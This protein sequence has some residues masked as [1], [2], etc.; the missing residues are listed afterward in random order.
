[1]SELSIMKICDFFYPG[2]HPYNYMLPSF[3]ANKMTEDKL[4]IIYLS[5]NAIHY[6]VT[7]ELP[8]IKQK[9]KI[10]TGL[11]DYIIPY[12]TEEFDSKDYLKILDSQYFISWYGINVEINH[13]KIHTIPIG[14]A[15]DSPIPVIKN[16]EFTYMMWSRG[17]SM[18]IYSVNNYLSSVKDSP[19]D[20]IKKKKD[21]DKLLYINYTTCNSENPNKKS[22]KFFRKNLDEYFNKTKFVKQSLKN[23]TCY[24]DEMRDYKFTIDPPGRCPDGYKTFES[25][26]VGT[27]PIK[28]TSMS[29]HLWSNLPVV[30]I[31]D[32]NQIT[33]EFLNNEY[34]RIISREDYDFNTLNVSYWIDYIKNT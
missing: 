4:Y 9:F 11:S 16:K 28:Y 27:I 10:I 12:L 6:F 29:D 14:T 33:E 26:I 18:N 15:R 21:S 8:Y 2:D 31:S 30:I 3:E 17:L 19:I 24:M 34:N 5:L 23:W 22:Y 13:P 20:L 1:M 25:I 7:H 32:I